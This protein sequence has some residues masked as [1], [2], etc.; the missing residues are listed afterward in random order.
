MSIT[1]LNFLY[2]WVSKDLS[3]DM[4]K[5][6]AR[7]EVSKDAYQAYLQLQ[8]A[9]YK[10]YGNRCKQFDFCPDSMEAQAARNVSLA[11]ALIEKAAA[12]GSP[13]ALSL[14]YADTSKPRFAINA[15]LRS[16]IAKLVIEQSA[17]QNA[18]IQQLLWA[19][20]LTFEGKYLLRDYKKSFDV[21]S[22]AWLKGDVQ[23]AATIREIF[24]NMQDFPNALLWQTRCINHCGQE[25]LLPQLNGEEMLAIQLAANDFSVM[26]IGH[27]FS[28]FTSETF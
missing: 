16:K 21:L 2:N 5:A 23:A 1:L 28:S 7:A 9:Y 8:E 15:E 6:Y 11:K 13:D 20:H 4:A 18:T 19:G 17:L 27:P 22:R 24:F 26:V 10:F 25:L 14:L 12:E 3:S